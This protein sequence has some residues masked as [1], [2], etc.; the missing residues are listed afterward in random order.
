VI[1]DKFYIL[2]SILFEVSLSQES[3]AAFLVNMQE[4]G[5]GGSVGGAAIATE[6]Q[7]RGIHLYGNKILKELGFDSDMRV[8]LQTPSPSQNFNSDGFLPYEVK[9]FDLPKD[10]DGQ[11]QNYDDM[12]ET[13]LVRADRRESFKENL[14]KTPGMI[15]AISHFYVDAAVRG[16]L[17]EEIKDLSLEERIL[18]ITHF[19][20]SP[21]FTIRADSPGFH[22]E[23]DTSWD[24][25]M[26]EIATLRTSIVQFSTVRER[27]MTAR[28]YDGV[29]GLTYEHILKN[30]FV[31]GLPINSEGFEVENP[32]DKRKTAREKLSL[33]EDATVFGM[34]TRVDTEKGYDKFLEQFIHYFHEQIES[35]VDIDSLPYAVV[36]GGI[37]S[38]D[39]KLKTRA[40]EV[41]SIIKDLPK[42]MQSY[43]RFSGEAMPAAEVMHALDAYFGPSSTETFHLAPKEAGLC[44]TSTTVDGE[45][46]SHG[47]PA[48]LS[49]IAA[50]RETHPDGSAFLF[51]EET[52]DGY[53]EGKV[54]I[55]GF[56]DAFLAAMNKH[57]RIEL[58][59]K[60]NENSKRFSLEESTKAFFTGLLACEGV[61]P[62][63]F[64]SKS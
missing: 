29:Y 26:Y 23:L 13:Y 46:H 5:A 28:A 31:A 2:L 9:F 63:F 45:T 10:A 58:G 25:R 40:E 47:I 48:F 54:Y 39:P 64:H 37:P 38:K 30:S 36:V 3:A 42:D 18:P 21:D 59:R 19:H 41:Q 44:I 62:N 57:T 27:E 53:Y 33:P 49:D 61:D 8:L 34:V 20:S 50:H 15:I 56:K 51:D 60:N 43:I 11:P 7:A 22:R 52:Y 17:I 35:G 1:N 14:E 16:N 55:N 6:L 24:R 32:E 12:I 4:S